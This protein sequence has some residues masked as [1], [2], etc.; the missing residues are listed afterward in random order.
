[1]WTVYRHPPQ[2]CLHKDCLCNTPPVRKWYQRDDNPMLDGGNGEVIEVSA[3]IEL[4]ATP[5]EVWELIKPAENAVLLNPH[6]IRAFHIPG[7]PRGVG[8]MQGFISRRDGQ[9][10]ISA[11]EILQEVTGQ[12][13]V[14]RSLGDSDDAGRTTYVLTPTKA[15]TQLE[16]RSRFTVPPDQSHQT[17]IIKRL[18]QESVSAFVQRVKV[19]LKRGWRTRP[20]TW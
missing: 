5:Q 8:E 3:S 1:M 7:T 16:Q 6:V 12:Y 13:A 15:G 11:I 18:H 17:N 9:E 14:T 10:T 20:A 4:E 2:N 19:A